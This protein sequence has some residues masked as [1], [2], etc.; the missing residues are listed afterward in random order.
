MAEDPKS[1]QPETEE[2][3]SE[4]PAAEGP[5]SDGDAPGEGAA[6]APPRRR[7]WRARLFVAAVV[8][9]VGGAYATWSSWGPAL[10][11]GRDRAKPAAPADAPRLGGLTERV[12]ALEDLSRDRGATA[13][14]MADLERERVRISTRVQALVE[15]VTELE[16]RL[17]A[18]RQMAEAAT[19][20]TDAAVAAAESLQR[21]S[22]RLAMLEKD[23][24]S[25]DA[26]L[27]RI[28]RLE[29]AAVGGAGDDGKVTAGLAEIS[30]RMDLLDGRMNPLGRRLETL[31]AAGVR[32]A[33]ARAVVLAVG[34]LRR[35]LATSAPFEREL[36]A[37]AALARSYP[38]MAADIA[39][40]EPFASA[41]VP[42]LA[43]LR[44]RFDAAAIGVVLA[45]PVVDGGGWVARAV[46][47]VKTLITVR[48]V[49][50]GGAEGG[51]DATLATA[52][53]SLGAGDLGAAIGLMAGL[54]GAPARAAA[55]WIKDARI[56]LAAE[57]AMAGLH[58]TAVSLLKP[59]Q[60]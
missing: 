42:T 58:V 31:E 46:N 19:P 23:Q 21:L 8:L 35:A 54:E 9:A 53:A 24:A 3:N 34:D 27:Q 17:S 11:G 28:S 45:A 59:A 36:Q 14:A 33:G 25:L 13:G 37:V 44:R 41:G 55:P 29:Q 10:T 18:V 20:P 50:T 16:Q 30:G 26:L 5:D 12:E 43:S 52:E 7:A 38:P 15:N 48:R 22:D 60:E 1:S 2:P 6:S 49:A 40:L 47:Q 39:R 56:R 4:G 57:R 32:S 51:L